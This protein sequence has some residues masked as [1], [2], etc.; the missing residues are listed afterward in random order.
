MVCVRQ[1]LNIFLFSIQTVRGV[2]GALDDLFPENLT[3][4]VA[5]TRTLRTREPSS[6]DS[7]EMFSRFTQVVRV[8]RVQLRE[9]KLCG[10]VILP[11]LP[12]LKSSTQLLGKS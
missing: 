3:I 4:Y 10:N 12:A 11:F 2:Q 9:K 6:Y 1:Y 7:H 8:H 5:T